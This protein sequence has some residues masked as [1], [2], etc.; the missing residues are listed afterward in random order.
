MTLKMTSG[1]AGVKITPEILSVQTRSGS[2]VGTAVPSTCST[3]RLRVGDFIAPISG[4][5]FTPQVPPPTALRLSVAP[6]GLR[7]RRCSRANRGT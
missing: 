3:A 4:R 5:N 2:D 7:D 6:Q 1:F